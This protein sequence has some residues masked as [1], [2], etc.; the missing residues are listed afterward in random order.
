MGNMKVIVLLFAGARDAVGEKS[1]DVSLPIGATAGKLL[2]ELAS[3]YP[4]FS[5]IAAV[6][7]T[8]VNEEYVTKAHVL[9]DGDTV[10]VIPPVSGGSINASFQVVNRPI[11]AD[12]L[13]E[14]VRS[15]SDGAIVTFSGVVRDHTGD[16]KTSHLLYEAY[17][18]MAEKKMAA[19]A[20]EARSQWA[21]GDIA[22]LH[23]VGRL[24]IGEISILA[25]V[26]SP[27][28]GPAFEACS[29][30]IDRLK[31]DVPVWKKEVGPAGNFWVEGPGEYSSA[32]GRME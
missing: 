7:Q 21:V 10:A 16:V 28:R 31:T 14:L 13:H 22:I 15:A 3:L 4:R 1:V 2:T 12:E 18:P 5:G 27:H 25:S 23:R 32:E 9:C 26:A 6:A 17:A 29:F 30:I 8:A 19:L 24:E 11:Q 20:H